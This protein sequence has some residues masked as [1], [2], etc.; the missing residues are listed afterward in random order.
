MKRTRPEWNFRVF[1]V[2]GGQVGVEQAA[3][4]IGKQL[5]RMTDGYALPG[6]VT[7]DGPNP[8]LLRD[9]Y[10][11]KTLPRETITPGY[12]YT[13]VFEKNSKLAD[14]T[15][16]FMDDTREYP[17]LNRIIRYTKTGTWNTSESPNTSSV[18]PCLVINLSQ[19]TT[20][21]AI[22]QLN[23]FIKKHNIWGLHVTGMKRPS[24]D[25]LLRINAI[26]RVCLE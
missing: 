17:A 10:Q 4:A 14:G 20:R 16:M 5:K 23:A 26:L 3:L 21:D 1:I 19:Y 24:P 6:Y 25:I 7:I 15:V 18:S 13:N 8:S 2:S 22:K 9:V 12:G 11:L